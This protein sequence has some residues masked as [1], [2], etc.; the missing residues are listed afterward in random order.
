MTLTVLRSTG[1]VFCS[2]LHCWN[3]PSV[4]LMIKLELWVIRRKTTEIKD[5]ACYIISR[6]HCDHDLSLLMLALITRLRKCL[7]GCSTVKHL[8][9]RDPPNAVPCRILC[10]S[11]NPHPSSARPASLQG[12]NCISMGL[13]LF[14][15]QF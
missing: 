7:S 15:L 9:L 2:M 8:L 1:Q 4:F 10:V 6:V 14:P 5:H 11:H 12:M 3:M 13:Q